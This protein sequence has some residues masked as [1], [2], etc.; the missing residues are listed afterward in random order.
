MTARHATSPSAHRIFLKAPLTPRLVLVDGLTRSGKMLTA[1]LVSNFHRM[2]YFQAFDPVDHIPILWR[3]GKL[4][5][6]TARA[7]LRMELD[8]A[9]YY[10]AIGRNLNLRRADSSSVHLALNYDQY[11][12]RADDPDT[13]GA[14]DRFNRERRCPVFFTHEMLPN[15]G[16]FFSIVDDLWVVE[17]VRHPVDLAYSWFRRG[18]GERWGADPL[19]FIPTVE[20]PGGP[21]PWFAAEWAE[22]YL[23]AA[24]VDRIIGGILSVLGLAE[25]ACDG[26]APERRQR[27]HFVC[28]ERL[29][30][31]PKRTVGEMAAFLDT[32]PLDGIADVLARERLPVESSVEERKDRFAELRDQASPGSIE[33]LVASSRGYEARWEIPNAV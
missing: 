1:K 23:A 17:P 32:E 28:Y 30:A 2:E 22:D 25:M 4:D 33:R 18:W 27:I 10:R 29:L 6:H 26:L 8:A 14:M 12:R 13:A 9:I 31:E 20:S 24:P 16:L 21:V 7:F 15:V 5:D 3:L 11:R 19:A